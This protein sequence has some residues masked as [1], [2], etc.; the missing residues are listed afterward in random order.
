MAADGDRVGSG[1]GDRNPADVVV[2]EFDQRRTTLEV[3]ESSRHDGDHVSG[4]GINV[5]GELGGDV[6]G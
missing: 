1:V 3:A 6:C 5:S 2:V 4:I